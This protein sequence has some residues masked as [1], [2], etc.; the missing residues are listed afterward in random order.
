VNIEGVMVAAGQNLKRLIQ[1]HLEIFSFLKFPSQCLI[2]RLIWTFS[3]ACN[4]VVNLPGKRMNK[5]E[6]QVF[7]SEN[8]PAER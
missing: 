5:K 8:L 6:R 3:T 4:I 1:H 7:Q 2:S